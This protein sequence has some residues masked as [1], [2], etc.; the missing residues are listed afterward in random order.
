MTA[1]QPQHPG[2]AATKWLDLIADTLLDQ[3]EDMM[4]NVEAF[5]TIL[6]FDGFVRLCLRMD[7]CPVHL[8]DTDTCADDNRADCAIYRH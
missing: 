3:P 4:E 5:R 8:T 2:D 6:T 7:V 1:T